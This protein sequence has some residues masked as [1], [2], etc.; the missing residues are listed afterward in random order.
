M[1]LMLK[2]FKSSLK[3]AFL[4]LI[5]LS[6]GLMCNSVWAANSIRIFNLSADQWARPRA[7][8]VIPQLESVRLA[9]AYWESGTDATILISHAGEDSGEIWA[10]ELKDWL[11]SL[12][13]PSDFILLSSGLQADDEIRI[14]VGSRQELTN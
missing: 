14:L 11:V 12:G 4:S 7:G 13:I 8:E 1:V 3:P 2:I 6:S 10:A 9:V 5:L